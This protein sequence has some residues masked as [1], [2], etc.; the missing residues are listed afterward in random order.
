MS[1]LITLLV[2]ACIGVSVF[3]TIRAR[4]HCSCGQ[5]HGCPYQDDGM[6]TK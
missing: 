2:F 6:C 5:C 4:R 1:Q 3:F